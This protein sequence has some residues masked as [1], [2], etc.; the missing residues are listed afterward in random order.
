MPVKSGGA[1]ANLGGLKDYMDVRILETMVFGIPLMLGLG[2]R[3]YDI[4]MFM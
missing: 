2:T 3:M 1:V 4:P